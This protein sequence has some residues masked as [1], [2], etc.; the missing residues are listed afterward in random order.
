MYTRIP[1]RDEKK[2]CKEAF[3]QME[4]TNPDQP[5]TETLIQLMEIVLRNNIF[6]FNGKA[7]KHIV[8]TAI[9]TKAHTNIFL[10]QLEQ[11]ILSNSPVKPQFFTI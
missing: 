8:G 7:Y 10:G 2:S 1:H 6:K 5:A 9:G 11:K 3:R 4:S